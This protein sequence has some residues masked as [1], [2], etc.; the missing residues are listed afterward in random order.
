MI[1]SGF[2]ILTDS[3]AFW[4]K[5]LRAKYGVAIGIPKKLSRSRSSFIWGSLTKVWPLLRENLVWSVGN[6]RKIRC[7]RDPWVPD[8]G[9]LI[10]MILGH[11]SLDL[12]Y[13]LSD[14]VLVDSNWN[15]ELF[16]L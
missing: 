9:P 4:V 5:V 13:L 7:W 2:K 8:V 11:S 3:R 14:M 16:R 6:G 15:L 1:K 10:S 12:D